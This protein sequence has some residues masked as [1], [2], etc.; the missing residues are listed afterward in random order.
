MLVFAACTQT[1]E[2]EITPE[3]PINEIPVPET[4]PPQQELPEVIATINGEGIQREELLQVQSQMQQGLEEALNQLISYTLILQEANVREYDVSQEEIEQDL[5]A[6]GLTLE[7][8]REILAAQGVSYEEFIQEQINEIKVM[9]LIQ[10][11]SDD[12][13]ITEEQAQQFYDEQGEAFGIE[14]PYDE[15]K[16]QIKEFLKQEETNNKVSEL[17]MQLMQEADIEI[18]I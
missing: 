11:L 18:H 1:T 8:A 16:E 12:V 10:E 2:E 14:E 15:I 4:Q 7:E 13:E 5:E 3:P 9:M 17:I 6:Q